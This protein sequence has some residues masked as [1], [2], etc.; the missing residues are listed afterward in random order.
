[1]QDYGLGLHSSTVAP[2]TNIAHLVGWGRGASG[3]HQC[4]SLV[5]PIPCAHEEDLLPP[6]PL[7]GGE[8]YPIC[9]RHSHRHMLLPSHIPLSFDWYY[10]ANVAHT[11]LSRCFQKEV[12]HYRL[13]FLKTGCSQKMCFHSNLIHMRPYFLSVILELN[14]SCHNSIM[15]HKHFYWG[16]AQILQ[17]HKPTTFPLHMVSGEHHKR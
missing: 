5:I 15:W 3:T 11:L 12:W 17:R 1:M 10:N 8:T 2:T 13:A 16:S 4:C 7:K 6:I 14:C 9:V